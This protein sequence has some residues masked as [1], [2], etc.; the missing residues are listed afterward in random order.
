MGIW[1]KIG[2]TLMA[3]WARNT[4]FQKKKL[5]DVNFVIKTSDISEFG[6]I[7]RTLGSRLPGSLTESLLRL[8]EILKKTSQKN[9]I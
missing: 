2:K 6:K 1:F 8:V 4:Q 7:L 9:V 5:K 3:S